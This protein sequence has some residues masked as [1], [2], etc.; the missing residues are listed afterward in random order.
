M[1]EYTKGEWAWRF[2]PLNP[3]S[4]V[5]ITHNGT[6][7]MITESLSNATRVCRALNSWADLYEACKFLIRQIDTWKRHYPT[8]KPWVTLAEKSLEEALAKADSK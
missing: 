7:V 2:D 6:T 3:S 8:I 1:A 4:K 5:E